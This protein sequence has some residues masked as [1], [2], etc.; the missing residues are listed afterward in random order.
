MT[1]RAAWD[2]LAALWCEIVGDKSPCVDEIAESDARIERN[3]K[4]ATDRISDPS[5]SREAL[6]AATVCLDSIS[7]NL[8]KER[9]IQ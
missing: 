4:A 3:L 9:G 1:G 2:Y 8:K 6:D 7:L 5:C